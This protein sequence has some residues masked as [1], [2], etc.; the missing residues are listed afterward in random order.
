MSIKYIFTYKTE[1][2]ED[3]KKAVDDIEMKKVLDWLKFIKAEDIKLY[4]VDFKNEL[5]S[6]IGGVPK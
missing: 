1:L 4:L 3:I 5:I 6:F 2:G